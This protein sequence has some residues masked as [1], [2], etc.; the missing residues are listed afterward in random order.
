MTHI[1]SR[2]ELGALMEQQVGP[3]ISLFLPT[4]RTGADMQQNPPRLRN[5][6]REAEYH[7]LL[8]NLSAPQVEA[9]L[10][11]V[12][13]LV[14]NEP[15]WLHPE[16]GLAVF[17]SPDLFRAYWLPGRFKEQAVVARHF[18]LKPL[19]PSLTSDG[20]FYL[21][22]LSHN[23]IRLLEGTRYGAREVAL[24]EAVPC[25]EAS[26]T[27]YDE[28]ENELQY[29][30]SSSG[31]VIGKGGRCA[32]VFHGQGG[33][34]DDEKGQ[35]L[36]YFR[37]IDRGLHA[38][39]GDERAPLV[40]A[41]VAS[42]FPL[43]R[44]ANTYPHL[45]EEGVP[46]NPDRVSVETL[47][48]QAWTVVG[49]SLSQARREAAARYRECAA[50]GRASHTVREIVP[51]AYDGRVESLFLE[52]GQEQWG[53]FNPTTRMLHVHRQARFNDDDLLDVAA[54]QTLLQGGSVYVVE[55][56]GM[57]DEGPLAAVLR[58]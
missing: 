8:N 32:T 7:L 46:G 17:R 15:F 27:R 18:Y 3:C 14:D 41:G 23:H 28:S 51:A 26:A 20:R 31:A 55:R 1:P 25:S 47:H 54:T 40:L 6:I 53:A 16:D 34:T 30:S 37:Q 43:Y 57:P 52:A 13:G 24:P 48:K 21:L 45:L 42:L 9:V 11:P 44:E 4:E 12:R 58:S 49:P 56:V 10:E 29:H 39:L 33:G 35:L 38:K 50:T 2:S 5:L 36:R 22:A 19:L